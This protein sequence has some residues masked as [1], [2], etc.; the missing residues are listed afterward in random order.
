MGLST[1]EYEREP[2]LH[3]KHKVV[4]KN[5]AHTV[6][7]IGAHNSKESYQTI[8]EDRVIPFKKKT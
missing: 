7:T 4:I 3:L 1:S 6:Y 2:S 8:N 5:K